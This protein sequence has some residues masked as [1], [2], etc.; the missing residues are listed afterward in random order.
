MSDTWLKA[1]ILVCT[2]GAVVLLVESLVSWVASSRATSNAINARLRMISDGHTRGEA[3]SLLRRQTADLSRILPPL[4][5]P[6]GE[7]LESMLTAAQLRVPISRMLV[8]LLCAPLVIFLALV[9]LV[10][11]SGSAMGFGRILLIA[12]FSAA[13]GFGIPVMVL[14]FKANRTRN[15][16]AN[17][18]SVQA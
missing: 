14:Q 16:W 11:S 10:L 9:A 3:L 8:I 4:L 6:L 5:L 15:H 12:A 2:F 7:K 18:H 13:L 1:I 17:N